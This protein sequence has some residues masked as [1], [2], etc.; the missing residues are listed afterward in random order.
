MGSGAF[1]LGVNPSQ[2]FGQQINVAFSGTV[3]GFSDWASGETWTWEGTSTAGDFTIGKGRISGRTFTFGIATDQRA[4][5]S[6]GNSFAFS[7]VNDPTGWEKQDVGAGTVNFNTSF[8]TDDSVVAFSEYQ[9]KLAVFGN[10]N[11]QIWKTD[12]DPNQFAKLQTMPNI[13]TTSGLSVIG[14]GEL[15]TFFLASSG[16]R[17]LRARE[18]TLNALVVDIGSPIDSL[19][20]ALTTAQRASGAGILEPRE[21]RYWCH[22]GGNI[23]VLSHFPSLKI[24]AWSIYVPTCDVR[25]SQ[26]AAAGN[27]VASALTQTVVPGNLYYCT[28]G[29]DEVSL[30]NGTQVLTANGYFIAQGTSITWAGTTA[31]GAFTGSTKPVTQ[32]SFTPEKFETSGDN[33]VV[34]DTNGKIYTYGDTLGTT[35][36]STQCK[37]QIPYLDHGHP[38]LE[39]IADSIDVVVKG[40]WKIKAGMDQYSNRLE[41]VYT[42]TPVTSVDANLNSTLGPP[43]SIPYKARGTHITIYA[44]TLAGTAEAAQLGMFSFHYKAVKGG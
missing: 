37:A 5:I 28:F 22:A 8:G 19:V 4:Y 15:D 23:Y 38:S 41:T 2:G 3:N 35:Y 39:K 42:P 12:A 31:T 6:I 21:H 13:G 44:E 20:Q 16:F 7:A 36:D 29:L 43:K 11:I 34:R 1:S 25:G 9:G 10:Y 17:S 18:T 24:S 40:S 30:T 33:V 32:T 26:L 14:Y 27:Y